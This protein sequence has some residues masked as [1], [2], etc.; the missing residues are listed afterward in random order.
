MHTPDLTAQNIEKLAQLFPDCV[1]EIRDDKG[2]I[3]RAIDFDQLRQELSNGVAEEPIEFYRLDWPGKRSAIVKANERTTD[4][5]RPYRDESVEFDT[6]KNVFIEGN[7]LEALKLIQESYLGEVDLIYIDPPYN[8]GSDL[9][10]NDTFSEDRHSYLINTG[11]KDESGNRMVPNT[12]SNGRFHSDWLTMLYPRLKLA[13]NLLRDTGVILVSIDDHELPNAIKL[14]ELVFGASNFIATLVWEKGRKNDA[15]L[16]SVGHEYVLVFAKSITAL[17]TAKTIW[18]EEKPG[19]REIWE[20]FVELHAIYGDA[21]NTIEI[22]LQKWVFR[23]TQNASFK[24]VESLQT[25]R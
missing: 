3:T 12:E 14:C 19:A 4:A 25:G 18:R 9:L 16:F 22:G 5:L 10:Y 24:E 15:R 2:T 17:K 7:N 20:K 6:T 8:T 13:R 23:I 1:T 21:Y 11:Q